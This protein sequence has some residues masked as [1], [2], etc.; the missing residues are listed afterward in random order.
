MLIRQ[1][2]LVVGRRTN[3]DNVRGRITDLLSGLILRRLT[4]LSVNG[5]GVLNLAL[6]ALLDNLGLARLQRRVNADLNL[7]RS[8][9]IPF[10]DRG[11]RFTLGAYPD[12]L[13]DWFANTLSGGLRTSNLRILDG[14]RRGDLVLAQLALLDGLLGTGFHR[15]IED[16]LGLERHIDLILGGL[17]ALGLGANTDHR[18]ARL[19]GA[20]SSHSRLTIRLTVLDL[21][22]GGDGLATELALLVDDLLALLQRVVK[23]NLGLERNRLFNLGHHR[24]VLGRWAVLDDLIDRSL[25]LLLLR[26][27][28]CLVAL[29]GEVRGVGLLTRNTLLD[30][31]DLTRLQLRVRP[32]LN[33]E[34]NL[35]GPRNLLRGLRRL[36]ANGDDFVD[37]L[38]GDLFGDL[39]IARLGV[40]DVTLDRHRLLTRLTLGG[41]F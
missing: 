1:L 6:L 28:R 7:E 3:L 22:S 34:R 9:L 27:H 15:V 21:L 38:L 5:D 29:R 41:H 36:G 40:D 8:V 11:C 39:G 19:L 35:S 4:V 12:D 10:N 25:G 31:L 16:E 14:L 24:G 33:I 30:N 23:D 32:G 18:V 26:G 20:L 13:L 2:S 37:R 17:R